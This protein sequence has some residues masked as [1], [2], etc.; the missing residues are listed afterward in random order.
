V[1]RTSHA[2][3]RDKGNDRNIRRQKHRFVSIGQ[4][5]KGLGVIED[6]FKPLRRII[7]IERNIG[8]AG[9]E[10]GQDRH[11]SVQPSLYTNCDPLFRSSTE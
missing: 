11:R 10:N 8:G 3:A 4:H 7:G 2:Y 5:S 9:V 6:I 1:W